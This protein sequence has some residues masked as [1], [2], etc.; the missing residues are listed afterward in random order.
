SFG[1]RVE[2]AA[3]YEV[4]WTSERISPAGR[5]ALLLAGIA[6][7]SGVSATGPVALIDLARAVPSPH[8]GSPRTVLE[9]AFGPTQ[10]RTIRH[11]TACRQPFEAIKSV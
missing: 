11:C 8:C 4:P 10:C 5:R 2:V 3:T 1:R 6:P 9:N 7:P